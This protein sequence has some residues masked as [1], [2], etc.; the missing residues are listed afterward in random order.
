[1]RMMSKLS[2]AFISQ[3]REVL[4][5]I[6]DETGERKLDENWL[7]KFEG[8]SPNCF[9]SKLP[10]NFWIAYAIKQA[11]K[12][13]K[14]WNAEMSRRGYKAVMLEHDEHLGLYGVTYALY[15]KR[16]PQRR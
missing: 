10:Q 3:I 12:I 6:S 9:P 7:L 11:P 4:D 13:Y 15:H 8:W 16:R 14:E 5:Q 2:P 1:M